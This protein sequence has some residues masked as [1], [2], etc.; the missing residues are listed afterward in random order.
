[1]KLTRKEFFAGALAPAAADSQQQGQQW[2]S[3]SSNEGKV[4]LRPCD[5]EFWIERDQPNYMDFYRDKAV[6]LSEV[7]AIVTISVKGMPFILIGN[8]ARR[9]MRLMERYQ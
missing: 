1:M 6:T 4:R 7:G 3:L 8:E 5:I 9:F 2:M